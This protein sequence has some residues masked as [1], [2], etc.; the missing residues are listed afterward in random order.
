WDYV[1]PLGLGP[2][3]RMAGKGCQAIGHG[4]LDRYSAQRILADA[5]ATAARRFP[6]LCDTRRF[7]YDIVKPCNP[8]FFDQRCIDGIINLW[9]CQFF[10]RYFGYVFTYTGSKL[11]D[12]FALNNY[13]LQFF[14]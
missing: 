9:I 11:V 6:M 4:M 12:F 3:R 8:L 13:F 7:V 14:V 10:Y 1:E 2:I 5:V